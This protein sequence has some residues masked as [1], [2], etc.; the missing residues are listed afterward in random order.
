MRYRSIHK[1]K[2]IKT[3]S[4]RKTPNIVRRP[5][6]PN[7]SSPELRSSV[8]NYLGDK[9]GIL[10]GLHF[11]DEM[12]KHVGCS[13]LH[14]LAVNPS[15]EEMKFFLQAANKDK[16]YIF[17]SSKDLY[18]SLQGQENLSIIPS[19]EGRRA[20]VLFC[21]EIP[22]QTPVQ[23]WTYV[24]TGRTIDH[25]LENLVSVG[26]GHPCFHVEMILEHLA[27]LSTAA[28]S[29]GLRDLW[30]A[31]EHELGTMSE[32]IDRQKRSYSV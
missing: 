32:F 20:H 15:N 26:G 13:Q 16:V 7:N 28:V 30:E 27:A 10:W 24:I 12:R 3:R 23:A 18:S 25:S 5:T 2:K 29:R 4:S 22:L 14:L 19:L 11:L 9:R 8:K 31:W 21:R 17:D 6:P 1:S